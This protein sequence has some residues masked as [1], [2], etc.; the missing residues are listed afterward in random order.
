MWS[1]SDLLKA[2]AAFVPISLK[3][4]ATSL[5]ISRII[6]PTS[7]ICRRPCRIRSGSRVNTPLMVLAK[8]LM[9][10]P[11]CLNPSMIRLKAAFTTVHSVLKA[12]PMLCT[13]MR[14]CTLLL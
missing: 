2:L 13:E 12:N 1:P 8:P 4:A 11:T 14:T 3:A 7:N 9:T 5:P 10:C 6:G